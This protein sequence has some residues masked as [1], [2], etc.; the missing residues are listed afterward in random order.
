MK[1]LERYDLILTQASA[2][3]EV[4][5]LPENQE[6]AFEQQALLAPKLGDILYRLCVEHGVAFGPFREMVI[7]IIVDR[8][9][10]SITAVEAKSF[11][12]D[13][14]GVHPLILLALEMMPV[15]A[16]DL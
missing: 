5:E 4:S 15:E 6:E 10:S 16:A 8:R 13:L 1:L 2:E 14:I 9:P 11:A 3:M 12:K 7:A